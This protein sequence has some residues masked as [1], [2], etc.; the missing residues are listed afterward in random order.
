MATNT[1]FGVHL[2][3]ISLAKLKRRI[4]FK[5]MRHLAFGRF[6]LSITAY[7]FSRVLTVPQFTKKFENVQAY[8]SAWKL[9]RYHTWTG[10]EI[11]YAISFSNTFSRTQ[12]RR[13]TGHHFDL[14][15]RTCF[16]LRTHFCALS[17][18]QDSTEMRVRAFAPL[19]VYFF[20]FIDFFIAL[21]LFIF[22]IAFAM[23][24]E[25]YSKL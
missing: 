18:S 17:E 21:F 10:P 22:F 20:F 24:L 3:E 23:M 2:T 8:G 7:L 4:T 15:A 14:W 5:E 11:K 6:T 13:V 25:C 9:P 12:K 16:C 1:V 19:I